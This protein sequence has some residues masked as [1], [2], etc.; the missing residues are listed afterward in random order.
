MRKLS[1]RIFCVP[2]HGLLLLSLWG[3]SPVAAQSLSSSVSAVPVRPILILYDTQLN[4]QSVGEGRFLRLADGLL[5]LHEADL[6]AWHLRRSETAAYQYDG[7]AWLPLNG[8]AGVSYK[9]DEARQTIQINLSAQAFLPNALATEAYTYIP[10]TPSSWG[11]FAN[12]DLLATGVQGLQQ[13]NGTFDVN[14]FG[15]YG[16]LTNSF[17][18]QNLWSQDRQASRLIRQSTLWSR[19]LPDTMVNVQVGDTQGKGGIWARPVYFGGIRWGRNFATQPGYITSPVPLLAGEAALP[20]TIDLYIDG[21]AQRHLN[22]PSGPFSLSDFPQVTG[23]GE[24]KLIVHDSL[25]RE[26]IITAPYSATSDLLRPG[27]VD[28]SVDAG[29]IR[30]NLGLISNDYGHFMAAATV[31]KGL[32][33][34]FTVE[35]RGEFLRDQ[36]TV[37][38]GGSVLTTLGI[39]TAAVAKSHHAVKGT[40]NLYTL[41]LEKQKVGLN[42]SLRGQV[43]SEN[44]VQ[45]GGISGVFNA[46]RTFNAS[47]GWQF[48]GGRSLGGSYVQRAMVSQPATKVASLNYG[49]QLIPGLSL[50]V[51]L[52]GILSEPKS[53]SL[54]FFL[55]KPINE[56]GAIAMLSGNVQNHLLE[57]P[58]LQVQQSAW[59]NGDWG[60][61]GKVVGGKSPLEEAGISLRS[62]EAT[63]TA[64]ASHAQV[65]T[66]YRVG[67]QGALTLLEGQLF[68]TQHINDSV[69]L[70]HVPGYPNLEVSSNNQIVARTNKNGDA[71]LPDLWSYRPNTISID[72]LALPMDA[73]LSNSK[74]ALVPYYRSAVATSFAV[75]RNR[76]AV[77]TLLLED[78]KPAP[79]GM[80]V[81]VEG[82]TEAFMVGM[83]GEV[84]ATDLSDRN[85]IQAAWRGTTCRFE[86]TIPADASTTIYSEPIICKGVQR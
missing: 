16:T 65:A 25:G 8:L 73:Q 7:Q 27:V 14:M 75:K 76:S 59:R 56:K 29:V 86:Y 45:I 46:V 12:Y 32:S 10:P 35:G 51:S 74:V 68:P 85:K 84:F 48:S 20:S 31:R 67:M 22:V 17:I 19:D 28:Y 83:R 80:T 79:V 77:L 55:I 15:P 43:S 66:N 24:A 71:L 64:D 9:V 50:N 57:Q 23:Q 42:F 69:G 18:G 33:E 60:Y 37:G 70:V 21:V 53:N 61:R 30:Q 1:L 54:M 49:M 2:A 39:A 38:L 40:G 26:Q 5:Y 81:H 4:Q 36:K 82:V 41:S 72:P 34:R 44:F 52:L 78:G 62:Q 13:L 11:S 6:A 47:L 3:S 58:T 63:Y